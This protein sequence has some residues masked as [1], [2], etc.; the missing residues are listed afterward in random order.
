[1]TIRQTGQS[2]KTDLSGAYTIT[3]VRVGD[4]TVLAKKPPYR[5]QLKSATITDGGAPPLDFALVR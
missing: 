1:M 5:R 4:I 2:A 3:D